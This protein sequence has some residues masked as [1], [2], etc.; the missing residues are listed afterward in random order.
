MVD[1]R[2]RPAVDLRRVRAV[3]DAILRKDRLD[4]L[5]LAVV[6]RVRELR[7][8]RVGVEVGRGCTAAETRKKRKRHHRMSEHV[9]S[10]S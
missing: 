2:V 5:P 6:E 8:E 9:T 7:V 10:G 4:V 1:D 3:E